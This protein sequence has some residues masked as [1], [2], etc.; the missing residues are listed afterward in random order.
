MHSQMFDKM[1]SVNIAAGRAGQRLAKQERALS[2]R[3]AACDKQSAGMMAVLV[4]G[5]QGGFFRLRH[6][7]AC[8]GR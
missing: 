3:N 1:L 5:G 4:R 7:P 6:M 2:I 8:A